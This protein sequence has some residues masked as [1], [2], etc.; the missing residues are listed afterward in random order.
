[1]MYQLMRAMCSH[2]LGWACEARP[3]QGGSTLHLVTLG[4]TCD[5]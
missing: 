5:R 2:C 3:G 4:C 1:M